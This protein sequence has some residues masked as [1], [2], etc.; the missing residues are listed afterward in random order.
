MRLHRPGEGLEDPARHLVGVLEIV[1][2]QG[3]LA[4]LDN[5]EPQTRLQHSRA[6][7]ELH[8]TRDGVTGRARDLLEHVVDVREGNNGGV[9]MRRLEGLEALGKGLNVISRAREG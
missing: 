7:A 4:E 9:G 8:L 3:G 2:R 5:A 1:R 6:V